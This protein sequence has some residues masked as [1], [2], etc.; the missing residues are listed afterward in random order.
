MK[1]YIFIDELSLEA[2]IGVTEE[3]RKI[4]QK[5]VISLKIFKD[6]EKAGKSDDLT[7]T[8]CYEE[9]TNLVKKEIINNEWNLVEKMGYD[10]AR[11][12]KQKTIADKIEI[13][14]KKFVIPNT[15]STG[16]KIT[17]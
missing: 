12:I 6:L 15:L 9:I 8:I 14:I 1:D 16:C 2:N 10:L 11:L 13:I 4:K 3:E 7:N 5:V 17:F